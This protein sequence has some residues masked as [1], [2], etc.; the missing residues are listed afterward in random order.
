M[1][2]RKVGESAKLKR[3]W[4]LPFKITKKINDIC[5]EME[6]LNWAEDNFKIVRSISHIKPYVGPTNFT[7]VKRKANPSEF[8][9]K[10]QFE[11]IEEDDGII[12]TNKSTINMPMNVDTEERIRLPSGTWILRDRVTGS[13]RE[14]DE[15]DNTNLPNTHID[16][17]P[18]QVENENNG[19]SELERLLRQGDECASIYCSRPTGTEAT[20]IICIHCSKRYHIRCVG[21]SEERAK[22]E[23]LVCFECES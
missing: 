8:K 12:K 3:E 20:Y 10:H 21:F 14:S 1:P 6:A 17:D 19:E 11:I 22:N 2:T 4:S 15:Y 13:S 5:Y 7:R 16:S 18:I 9:S 23:T